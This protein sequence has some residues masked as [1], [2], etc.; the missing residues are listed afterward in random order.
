MTIGEKI[1]YLRTRLG[2]TRT[3]L[4]EISKIHPV[5]IRKYETNKIIPKQEQ[6]EK[7]C[8]ALCV[9][10][11]ALSDNAI[12]LKLNTT[13]DFYGMLITFHHSNIINI[14]GER[15]EDGGLIADTVNFKMNSILAN[16]I[17]I[18]TSDNQVDTKN[19]ILRLKDEKLLSKVIIWEK[20][21]YLY[22]K[23]VEE[24]RYTEDENTINML[25]NMKDSLELVELELML[26]NRIV[27]QYRI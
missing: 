20:I 17:K 15:G 11:F 4:A 12:K 25:N 18:T 2:I 27:F 8:D 5:S 21:N 16:F 13:S 22:E 6:I 24:H 7:I 3:T 14:C 19:L 26:S 1:K 9:S 10:T 23:N